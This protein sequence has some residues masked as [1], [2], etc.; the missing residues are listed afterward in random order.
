MA[1]STIDYDKKQYGFAGSTSE[2]NVWEFETE[3]SLKK[4]IRISYWIAGVKEGRS[5]GL[6]MLSRE[7]FDGKEA[8]CESIG[9]WS[10]REDGWKVLNITDKD[11]VKKTGVRKFSKRTVTIKDIKAGKF[12]L[13]FHFS[14]GRRA[15]AIKKVEIKKL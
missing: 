10:S 15:A 4:G 5:G 13:R 14:G 11:E 7:S 12:Q 2:N 3:Y 1:K 8:E 6:V 9:A